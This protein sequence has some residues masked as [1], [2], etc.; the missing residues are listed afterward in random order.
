V[1]DAQQWKQNFGL[2][3]VAVLA[4]PAWTLVD[5]SIGTPQ[6]SIV[7]PRTMEIVTVNQGYSGS[8]PELE[9]LAQ[10]NGS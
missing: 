2:E 8:Y 4:D 10:Q 7:N 5:G 9:A 1:A 6:N 3:S